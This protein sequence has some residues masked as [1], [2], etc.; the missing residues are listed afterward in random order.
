VGEISSASAVKVLV[1]S[2]DAAVRRQFAESLQSPSYVV[3]EAECASSAERAL[4]G[5]PDVIVVDW[6]LGGGAAL[7]EHVRARDSRH[8]HYIV[9]VCAKPKPSDIAAFVAAGADDF[10]AAEATREEI[11]VRVDALRRICGWATK[12]A[13]TQ[14]I[15]IRKLL[16]L[17]GRR[18]WRELDSIVTSEIGDMLGL[19][20]AP[21]CSDATIRWCGSVPLTVNGEQVELQLAV[22]LADAGGEQFAHDVLGA[23]ASGAAIA[24]A[25]REMANVAGG[26]VKRAALGDGLVMTI[27]LP[28]DDD[29]FAM[30]NARRWASATSSGLHLVFAIAAAPSQRRS[31]NRAELREGMVVVRD[32]RTTHG[33]LIVAAG[34]R[35]TA[36]TVARLAELLEPD[37]RVDV[38]AP[39]DV[40]A[41]AA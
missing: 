36:T 9:A 21:E 37:A 34:T 13:H 11:V 4:A 29:V 31:M 22:G 5:M 10:M 7:I 2:G 30:A 20:L 6:L 24:D 14:T 41:N 12:P 18:V 35:L 25:L 27:G 28:S 19:A 17:D 3:V 38:S 26:A 1:V 15:R 39:R 32:V 16:E 8:R 23:E 40:A 33:E